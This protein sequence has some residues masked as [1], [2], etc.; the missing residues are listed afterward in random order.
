MHSV[1]RALLDTLEKALPLLRQLSAS[2]AA[3]KPT[4]GKWSKQE[5]LGHLIDS[6]SNNQQKFVR[7]LQAEPHVD[8]IGYEQNFWVSAQAYQTENWLNII[9]LWENFNR[10]LAHIIQNTPAEKLENTISINGSQPFTLGFIMADYGEH[11]KHHLNQILPDAGFKSA[12]E[13]LY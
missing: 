4:P 9:A 11:L 2:E 3:A 1:S 8:F 7:T 12:F 13:N 10:H 6:A 5:I